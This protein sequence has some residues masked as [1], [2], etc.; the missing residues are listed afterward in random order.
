MPEPCQA[1]PPSPQLILYSSGPPQTCSDQPPPTILT[2]PQSPPLCQK[3][4]IK[5]GPHQWNTQKQTPCK[6]IS[7]EYPKVA[8]AFFKK[9]VVLLPIATH[10]ESTSKKWQRT[11]HAAIPPSESQPCHHPTS[12]PQNAP[13]EEKKL[14]DP[15]SSSP[16]KMRNSLQTALEHE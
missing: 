5:Q 10:P 9:R 11:S 14:W 4:S 6:V 8:D 3:M 12:F 13:Q 2:S 15:W 16:P 7:L 1:H